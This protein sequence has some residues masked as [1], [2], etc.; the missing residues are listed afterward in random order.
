M[1]K[2][3]PAKTFLRRY[4]GLSR[5]VDAL[6]RSIDIAMERAT[7]ISVKLKEIRVLSSPAEHDPMAADVCTAVDACKMLFDEKAQA[8]KALQEILIAIRAVPDER[9]RAVL[10]MRYVEGREFS[11]IAEEMHFSEPAIYVA[12]G[13]ALVIINKWLKE[14]EHE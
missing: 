7:S 13:R 8:E 1:K 4:L 9:Q 12:H 2:E 10:T 11:Q 3:N 5:R 14:N 6:T